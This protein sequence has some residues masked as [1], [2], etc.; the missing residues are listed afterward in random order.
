MLEFNAT[1]IIAMISFVVFIFIMNTIFY[2]PILNI[3]EERKKLID[4]YYNDA[5]NFKAEAENIIQEKDN[6][7]AET[8]SKAKA[9]ISKG[10]LDAENKARA[11]TDNAKFE[12]REKIAEQKDEL[13]K[14]TD[15]IKDNLK[16]EVENLSDVIVSR[17]LE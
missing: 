15:A 7:L 2:K 3:I 11:L 4:S 13:H 9:I 12:A 5:K 14:Q 16:T 17:I 10:T 8:L 1:F 6:K